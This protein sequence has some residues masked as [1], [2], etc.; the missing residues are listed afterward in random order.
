VDDG[1]A[2]S[3]SPYVSALFDAM[4]DEGTALPELL[5]LVGEDVALRTRDNQRPEVE[6]LTGVLGA[7]PPCGAGERAGLPRFVFF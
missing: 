4:E 5:R 2:G 1:E 7:M 6:D 3:H